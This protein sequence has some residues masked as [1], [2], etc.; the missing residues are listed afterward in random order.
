MD[1]G[2][3]IDF[4]CKGNVVRYYLGENGKQ[5]GDD[6][7]DTPYEH[8]AGEVYANFV[9]GYV[10]ISYPFDCL[11]LEPCSGAWNSCWSK[12]D[13]MERKVPCIIVVPKDKIDG[14]SDDFARYIGNDDVTKVYFGD[15]Y[16]SATLN[17]EAFTKITFV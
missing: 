1:V 12:K 4:E 13:M 5:W 17:N 14:W 2:K 9:T 11:V 6:W 7:D 3:I 10:D 16:S 8:N 15:D